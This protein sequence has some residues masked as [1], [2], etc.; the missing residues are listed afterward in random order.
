MTYIEMCFKIKDLQFFINNDL[1][2]ARFLL[3]YYNEAFMSNRL[4]GDMESISEEINEYISG[5]IEESEKELTILNKLDNYITKIVRNYTE[6]FFE[7][8]EEFH[9]FEAIIKRINNSFMMRL[10]STM[11]VYPQYNT[12]I[13][14]NGFNNHN[15]KILK[16]QK[17]IS[18][19]EYQSYLDL[20]L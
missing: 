7:D 16:R 3:V 11:G 13:D 5:L 14:T 15:Y 20:A 4:R 9:L 17:Y 10:K 18:D 19:E 1:Q 8:S 2:M 6:V 12:L